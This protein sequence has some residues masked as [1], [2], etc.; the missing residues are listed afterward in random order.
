MIRFAAIALS[1][2]FA[3]GATHAQPVDGRL[4]KIL[5]SKSI[6]IAYR[7]D[8]M[9]FSFEEANKEVAGFSVDICKAVVKSLER[10]FKVQGKLA[11]KWVPVSTQTRFETVAKGQ[12]DMEC[13]S[14]TVTLSRMR[15]VDFSSYTFVE[16]TGVVVR[17]ASNARVFDDL[18][19]KRIAVVA[20]TTNERAVNAQLKRRGL[21]ATVIPFKTREEGFAAVEDGKA[22]AFA[23]DKLLLVGASM[24]AK[25]AGSL[26]MLTD[27]LS[28][29]PYAIVL[30]RGD[31]RFRLAVN[32]A[33]AQLYPT[34]EMG[35]IFVRWFG[36]FGKPT[37]LI[38]AVYI[39]GSIPE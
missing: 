7:A 39:F 31:A 25:Q 18:G 16:S 19:G 15:Q 30:P 9:P 35:Q 4:K 29:E 24:K 12:A 23:S 2:L 21:T 17:T 34:D 6:A 1:A 37:G 10:Q 8:A 22:D 5:D 26:V 3:A 38:E 27:D 20:G 28:F 32:T 33:L 11:I 36:S 14:S 13:S